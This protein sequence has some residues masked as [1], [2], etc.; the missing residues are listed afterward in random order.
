[1]EVALINDFTTLT[2]LELGVEAACLILRT[3]NIPGVGLISTTDCQ[4]GVSLST[5]IAIGARRKLDV[6]AR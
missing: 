6:S 4:S 5:V 2:N 3:Q 1:M